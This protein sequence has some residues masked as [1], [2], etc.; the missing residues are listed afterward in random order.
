MI[1]LEKICPVCN[2]KFKGKKSQI[3]C[4]RECSNKRIYKKISVKCEICGKELERTKSEI[5]R[6]KHN[7]CSDKC[8]AKGMRIFNTGGNNPNYKGANSIISCSYCGEKIKVLDCN[9]KN[10]DGSIK[11]IFYCNTACKSLHQKQLLKGISNPNFKGK[12]FKIKCEYCGKEFNRAEWDIKNNIHQYCSQKCKA[13]HQKYILLKEN[14]P[15]YKPDLSEEYRIEHRIIEGYNTW[16]RKVLERDNYTCQKC[17]KKEHL[18]AHHIENYSEKEELR[19][20]INN[21]ITLCVECH[22][23]FHKEFGN[24]NNNKKQIDI[25]LN[26]KLIP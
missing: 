11:K 21:G 1:L 15:N 12:T 26:N 24:K 13:E 4:S 14:N 9:L 3:C 23:E 5:N 18:A 8:K 10:S 7:Y 25:F 22:K 16:K 17:N 2:K 6:N 20:D 19:T